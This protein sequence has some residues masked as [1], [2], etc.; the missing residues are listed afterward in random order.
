MQT[1]VYHA[2]NSPASLADAQAV[3]HAIQGPA[4]MALGPVIGDSQ[5]T[6]VTGDDLSIVRLASSTTT[7]T[8][9]TV[10]TTTTTI[11]GEKPTTTTT[12][13]NVPTT[14]LDPP[15][16]TTDKKLSA[17]TLVVQPLEPWDPRSCTATG[18]PGA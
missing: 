11:K 13:A 15:G 18:G 12:N 8:S 16:V 7:P 1:I 5:V 2:S 10:S 17:P 9:T 14:V 3:L 4:I 6:V